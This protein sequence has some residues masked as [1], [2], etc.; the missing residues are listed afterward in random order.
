MDLRRYVLYHGRWQLST[1]VMVGPMWL[2]GQFNVSRPVSLVLV[3]AMGACI[4][5]Y[6]DYW[7]FNDNE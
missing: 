7:I 1:L 6:I 5:Y 2:L 3:Q 4:F